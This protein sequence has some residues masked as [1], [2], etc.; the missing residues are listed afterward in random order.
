MT[1]QVAFTF[2]DVAVI[3]TQEEWGQLSPAQGTLY[4]EVMLE[5]LG[6]LVS[7]GLITSG[8][9]GM[10]HLRLSFH[11]LAPGLDA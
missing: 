4:Q 11:P 10:G 5:T 2:E 3:F 9:Q 7:L 8:F 1:F 6:L